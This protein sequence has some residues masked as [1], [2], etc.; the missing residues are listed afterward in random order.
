M[1]RK[2]PTRVRAQ[3][4]RTGPRSTA[5]PV[6]QIPRASG[7]LQ[8]AIARLEHDDERLSRGA[9]ASAF[10]TWHR[11]N[12]GPARRARDYALHAD[13][14]FCN[15]PGREVLELAIGLLPRRRARELRLLVAPLDERYLQRTVPLP[16]KPPGPWWT[17]RG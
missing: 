10:Q 13:C 11:A 4:R 8:A 16:S 7:A 15:P 9:V 1:P 6:P 2:P 14:E 5:R 3:Q 17:R 12:S